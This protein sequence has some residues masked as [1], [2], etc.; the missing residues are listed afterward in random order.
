MKISRKNLLSLAK[1]KGL[2]VVFEAS[3]IHVVNRDGKVVAFGLNVRDAI[4]DVEA[5]PY[6][7]TD[8]AN[9]SSCPSGLHEVFSI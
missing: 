9:G 1:N 8:T 4:V 6:D 5:L 3:S 7:R 2:T